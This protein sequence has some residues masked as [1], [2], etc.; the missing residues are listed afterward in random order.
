VPPSPWPYL[1]QPGPLAFAH[2]GGGAENPENTRRAFAHAVALGYRYL[3]TDAHVTA[4]GH[5][6]AFHDDT[7]DRVTDR[8]GEIA[9]LPWSAVSEAR[10]DGEPPMLLEDLLTAYPDVRVNVEPKHDA[11]VEPLAALINRLGAVDRVGVGSFHSRRVARMRALCG[12]R[13]CT[14]I[15]P[16]EILRMRYLPYGRW[17]AG[18]AQV[19]ERWGRMTIV[20]RRFVKAC[21]RRALQVHVWTVDDA[22]RM[23]HLLDL[24]VDGLMTDR[25]TLLKQVLQDR[26]QW[27]GP[28]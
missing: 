15:G 25:P 28:G 8:R 14:S 26:G 1:D 11:V 7:L 17:T 20:D 18:S 16:R 21:H 3:E 22:D 2:R 19:P 10:L 5:V 23:H 27:V 24:G 9:T 13:L 6:V 12:A 4:D